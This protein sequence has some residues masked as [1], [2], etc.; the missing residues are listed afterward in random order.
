[1]RHSFYFWIPVLC[2]TMVACAST[3][4]L[5]NGWVKLG[6][7]TVNHTVDRDEIRVGVRDGD[8]S[9]IKLFVRQRAVTFR[10]VKI[11][12]ANGDV[13]DVDLRRQI[14]AGGETRV[15]DL[16][17]GERVIEKVVFWYNTRPA[18]GRR[19]VVELYGL[20]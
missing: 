10:D 12:Y 15:I 5:P 16:R 11:H 6:D 14:P 19:A 9:K 20:R 1:M 7:R 13:Q 2:L 18:R 3:T 17:G 8:F 4:S